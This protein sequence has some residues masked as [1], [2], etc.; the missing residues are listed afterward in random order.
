MLEQAEGAVLLLNQ[1]IRS[2]IL[3]LLKTDQPS[4]P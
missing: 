1:D 4:I 2:S 3:Q